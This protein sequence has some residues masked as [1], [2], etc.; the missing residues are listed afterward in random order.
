MNQQ[1]KKNIKDNINNTF[2]KL[3]KEKKLSSTDIE[4][5]KNNILININKEI[6]K[7]NECIIKNKYIEKI[8]ENN[9]KKI[10]RIENKSELNN[11]T[12]KEIQE[13]NKVI[14]EYFQKEAYNQMNTPE[15][16]ENEKVAFFL[17]NVAKIA[18]IS[19]N[20]AKYLFKEMK[21]KYINQNKIN[22]DSI[23]FSKEFSSW[24]K[25]IE[26][27]NGLKNMKKF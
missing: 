26:K 13:E 3:L 23:D 6:D 9:D 20:Q 17:L 19:Y 24:V 15:D 7:L 5:W 10:I 22:K 11:F 8:N 2:Y 21:E 27:Q 25:N 12:S 14:T 16:V 18:R 4:I 1:I